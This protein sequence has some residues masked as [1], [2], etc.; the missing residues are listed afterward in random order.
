VSS[1]ALVRDARKMN[2]DEGRMPGPRGLTEGEKDML[3]SVFAGYI[4]YDAAA[5]F[6]RKWQFFQPK[7]TTMAPDGNMYWNPA[8]YLEDFSLA[9]VPLEK[10]AWFVH[11]GAHLYQHYHLRWNVIVRGAI[12]RRYGYKLVAGKK[13]DKYGL[14]Q[15]GS[16]A[17][18]YFTLLHQGCIKPPYVLSDFLDA[19]PLT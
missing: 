3:A 8:D 4:D 13:F 12:D 9:T 5:I 11:E 15:M 17:A 19:L 7:H 14:E 16:I 18:D 10:R 2:D 6:A 1:A